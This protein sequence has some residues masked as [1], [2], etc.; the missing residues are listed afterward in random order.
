METRPGVADS[1]VDVHAHD[2]YVG[3][4]GEKKG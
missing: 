4:S 2:V 1:T 3:K